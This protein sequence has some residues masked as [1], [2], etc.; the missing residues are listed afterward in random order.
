MKTY[1]ELNFNPPVDD[2][3][4]VFD[5]GKYRDVTEDRTVP[6]PTPYRTRLR[7]CPVC[8]ERFD[9]STTDQFGTITDDDEVVMFCSDPCKRIWVEDY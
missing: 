3:V 4:P 5:R 7:V 6:V 1:K 8:G 2:T 9:L